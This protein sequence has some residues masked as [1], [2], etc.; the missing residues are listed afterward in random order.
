MVFLLKALSSAGQ[1]A[2]QAFFEEVM[3]FLFDLSLFP[4]FLQSALTSK[5]Q[6]SKKK[7]C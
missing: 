1:E 2:R 3:R 4:K 7:S 6:R 5:K